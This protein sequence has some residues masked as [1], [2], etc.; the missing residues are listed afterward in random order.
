MSTLRR[1]LNY[2]KERNLIQILI[3]LEEK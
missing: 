3:E 2:L 1:K